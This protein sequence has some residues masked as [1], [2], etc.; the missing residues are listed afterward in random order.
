[1][2]MAMGVPRL[3]LQKSEVGP[4]EARLSFNS[5]GPGVKL[6]RPSM[7]A[8]GF[9]CFH[10]EIG[11]LLINENEEVQEVHKISNSPPPQFF[12]SQCWVFPC[13]SCD[14][15]FSSACLAL[16]VRLFWTLWGSSYPQIFPPL[17]VQIQV[18]VCLCLWRPRDTLRYCSSDTVHLVF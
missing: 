8:T 7:V 12:C 17:Y 6:K 15:P 5:V 16:A 18:H 9:S 1:M 2:C 4:G 13:I 14:T 3:P 11:A 10:R